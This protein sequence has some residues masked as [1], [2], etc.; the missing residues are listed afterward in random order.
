MHSIK[1]PERLWLFFTIGRWRRNGRNC[2]QLLLNA[3][4][5]AHQPANSATVSAWKSR[6]AGAGSQKEGARQQK[7]ESAFLENNLLVCLCLGGFGGALGALRDQT[8]KR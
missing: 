2:T 1:S 8:D 5:T 4:T 6:C 7:K 3:G